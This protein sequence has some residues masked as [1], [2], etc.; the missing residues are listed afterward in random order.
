M[1]EETE[2]LTLLKGKFSRNDGKSSLLVKSLKSVELFSPRR[3]NNK[4][5]Q[6]SI[7]NLNDEVGIRESIFAQWKKDK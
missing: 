5:S 4:F 7:I 6:N 1:R 2:D 3:T